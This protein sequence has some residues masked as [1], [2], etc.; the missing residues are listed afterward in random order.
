M[1]MQMGEG[2]ICYTTRILQEQE[3]NTTVA[4]GK[5]L[6]K[7]IKSRIARM[8]A[9]ILV[10]VVAAVA[11]GDEYAEPVYYVTN[12]GGSTSNAISE[13]VFTCQNGGVESDSSYAA[14]NLA[15]AGTLVKRGT[16]WVTIEEDH[17]ASTGDVHVEAGV[18]C[19]K[20]KYGRGAGASGFGGGTG[21]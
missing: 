14:F 17:S 2:V 19:C 6:C 1:M 7:Q 9:G 3:R 12:P 18:L 11:F 20:S 5:E 16:G 15:T 13:C 21:G 4:T 10:A 8:L